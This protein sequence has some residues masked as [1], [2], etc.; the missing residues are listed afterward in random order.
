[1]VPFVSSLVGALNSLKS[2]SRGR[3]RQPTPTKTEGMGTS[4]ETTVSD[5]GRMTLSR[6]RLK[7]TVD[8]IRNHLT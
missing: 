2:R 6:F 4:T 5:G 1:M 3:G 7:S 8:I